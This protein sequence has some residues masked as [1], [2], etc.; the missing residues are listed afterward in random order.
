M[1]APAAAAP[2]PPK[3]PDAKIADE[4]PPS[5]PEGLSDASI[6][7][8]VDKLL[9]AAASGDAQRVLPFYA[10]RVDYYAMGVVGQT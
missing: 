7:D 4:K 9:K 1:S 2:I 6:R 3:A 10:D 8:F 5:R